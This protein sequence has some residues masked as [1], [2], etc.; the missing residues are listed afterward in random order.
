MKK[1]VFFVSIFILF[2]VILCLSPI[3]GDDWGNYIISRRGIYHAFGEAVGMYFAWEGRFVSRVLIN[4]LT[5]HKILW[6]IVNSI[7]ILGIVYYFI[8]II[9]AIYFSTYLLIFF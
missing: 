2:F 8:K 7:F 9:T 6:N 3:C 1:K 5:S 4:L